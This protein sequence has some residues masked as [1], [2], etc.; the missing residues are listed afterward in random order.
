MVGGLISVIWCF[1]ALLLSMV[2]I[3][4]STSLFPEIDFASKVARIPVD[5]SSVY[6]RP[7]SSE[8]LPDVL[9]R[10]SNANSYEIRKEFAPSRFYVQIATSDVEGDRPIS[11]M[12]DDEDG[13]SRIFQG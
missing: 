8:S 1:V 12:D 6:P 13:S 7:Q 5:I 2:I 9:S 3:T 4:P 11:T 10:L